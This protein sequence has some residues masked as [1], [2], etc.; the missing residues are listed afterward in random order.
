MTSP[1][2]LRV[3]IWSLVDKRVC[4]IKY[5]KDVASSLAFSPDGEFLAVVERRGC[6][7]HVSLF[8]TSAWE[9]VKRFRLAVYDLTGRQLGELELP[10]SSLGVSAVQW[11]PSS[12]LLAV[13]GFDEK[14]VRLTGFRLDL[15]LA[16]DELVESRPVTLRHPRSAADGSKSRQGVSRLLFSPDNL[17]LAT[18]YDASP[19]CVWIWSMASLSL[20]TLL[21]HRSAV[22]EVSPSR[23]LCQR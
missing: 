20:H 9:L 10:D 13:A 4:Y 18:R 16:A 7:D 2:W 3:T 21:M 8:S 15:A 17:Y 22:R 6:R 12:Q 23:L 5:L 19:E 11:C 14:E 1:P